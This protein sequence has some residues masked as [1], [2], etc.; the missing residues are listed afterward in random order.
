MMDKR[1]TLYTTP[2]CPKC[3]RVEAFLRG[4]EVA[5]SV[6]DPERDPEAA[7]LLRELTG[8]DEVLVPAVTIDGALAEH[9]DDSLAATLGVEI[10]ALQQLPDEP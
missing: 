1:V 10:P 9:D 8:N 6:A 5:Y 4:A 7:R 2:W 3:R